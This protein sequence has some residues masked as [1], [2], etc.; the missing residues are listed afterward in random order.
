MRARWGA[1]LGL[2]AL[3]A[4]APGVG[5]ASERICD[6]WPGEPEPL[7]RAL[8]PDPVRARW[9]ELRAQELMVLAQRLEGSQSVS[10]ERL[11]R[12][13]ACLDPALADA[14]PRELLTVRVHRP[15]LTGVGS[16]PARRA[17][18]LGQA[19]AGV[20]G[21]VEVA[22]SGSPSPPTP[23]EVPVPLSDEMGEDPGRPGG[24][25]GS[26][27][28]PRL[29]AAEPPGRYDP[30]PAL[31]PSIVEPEPSRAAVPPPPAP[32]GADPEADP[33]AGA[34]A[35]P[36][37]LPG[38]GVPGRASALPGS[39]RSPDAEP[40][41]DPTPLLL[42]AKTALR[43]ARF[44]EAIS[45]ASEGRQSL[46]R[47]AA[48]RGDDPLRGERAELAVVEA[49]AQLALGRDGEA[50]VSFL[51]ARVLDPGLAL[52]PTRHSPKVLSA[53]AA[54]DPSTESLEASEGIEP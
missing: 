46:A 18:S 39:G 20:S 25:D 37:R 49:T 12:H 27:P 30:V 17:T 42:G 51:R 8:D 52:D 31:P 54:A 10:A 47:A 32:R 9:A 5:R 3:L 11:R 21:R 4:L 50:H 45:R 7:A 14:A 22:D 29:A 44:E 33:G 6:A 35:L 28:S 16:S 40:L 24:P 48:T 19:L 34:A 38:T 53:F 1:R 2:V 23:R 41:P 13:A 26:A 15:Q 36:E 43:E